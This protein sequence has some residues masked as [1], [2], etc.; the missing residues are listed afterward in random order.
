MET[1][2]A[3]TKSDDYQYKTFGIVEFIVSRDYKISNKTDSIANA[4]LNQNTGIAA[5]NTVHSKITVTNNSKPVEPGYSVHY[6][7]TSINKTAVSVIENPII[8]R[9]K[10][11]N[12]TYNY[13]VLKASKSTGASGNN[14]VKNIRGIP[15]DLP[16]AVLDGAIFNYQLLLLDAFSDG[17]LTNRN[18]INFNT[19]NSVKLYEAPLPYPFYLFFTGLLA[20]FYIRNKVSNWYRKIRQHDFFIINEDLSYV[21]YMP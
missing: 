15:A 16:F 7:S 6:N 20:L 4:Q 8:G 21:F 9:N 13:T 18:T 19:F 11:T 1:T 17:L 3:P 5:I 10:N 2:Q 12:Q 14:N